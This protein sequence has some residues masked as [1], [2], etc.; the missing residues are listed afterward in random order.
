[1]TEKIGNVVLDMTYY[2]GHLPVQAGYFLHCGY[3]GHIQ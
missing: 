1:M 3:S 2:P